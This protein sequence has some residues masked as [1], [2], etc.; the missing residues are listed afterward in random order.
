MTRLARLSVAAQAHYVILR[1]VPD[2][3]LIPFDGNIEKLF[4]I[5]T[6]ESRRNQVDISGF[7]VF[8]DQIHL[9]LTPREKAEDLSSFV[10]QLSRL[11]SRYFNEE[12]SR[13]GKIWQGRFESS[14]IQGKGVVLKAILW[15]EWLPESLGYGE[16]EYYPWTSYYHHS[17]MRSD[18]FVVPSSE[19]WALGNTPF[20]R[21]KKY[22]ELFSAGPDKAFGKM[23]LSRV[24]RGWPLADNEYL[25]SIGIEKG[26]ISPQR[27]RGRPSK[28]PNPN[29][30]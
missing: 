24:R 25:E 22:K 27:K 7:A 21:Q 13:T 2:I 29:C 1:C 12:F 3:S 16:P 9:V 15:M 30:P 28:N 4:E 14:L 17:G 18:Y 5:F 8:T 11:Y 10:Q 26:R 23:L 6:T 19:Y 20:E